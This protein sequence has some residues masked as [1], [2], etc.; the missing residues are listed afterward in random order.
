MTTGQIVSGG[1]ITVSVDLWRATIDNE[2]VEDLSDYLIGGSV[3]LNLDRAV[4]LAA[5][6]MLR[7]TDLVTP[8]IDYLAPVLRLEYDDGTTTVEQQIGLYATRVPGGERTLDTGTVI[9]DADDLTA[10]M[11]TAA[12]TDT[13]NYASGTTIPNA[14]RA[15]IE[16]AG[17]TR[18]NVAGSSS[19]LATAMSFRPGTSYLEQANRIGDLIAWYDLGMDLDGKVSTPGR[20]RALASTEPFLTIT[21]GDLL[22]PV[23]VQPPQTGIANVVV[24]INDDATA[25]PLSATAR[26]DDASSPTSTV[27][28]GREIVRQETLSGRTTQASLDAKALRL[29][30]ESRTY[31]Q[32]I[33]IVTWP[34]PDAL[35]AHQTVDLDLTGELEGLSGLWWVRTAKM[36]F[37]PSDAAL[38]LELNRVTDNLLAVTI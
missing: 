33:R 12:S 15:A 26:N 17:I 32:V 13:V 19:T 25:A 14:I 37:T 22:A 34:N 5:T 35:I 21:D 24:V 31:Y 10:V 18:H 2:W 27:N 38:T 23:Q 11:A 16:A 30:Q 28:I 3:D 9:F 7:D 36:G 1:G 20:P 4:K 8:Y 6:F 29:L